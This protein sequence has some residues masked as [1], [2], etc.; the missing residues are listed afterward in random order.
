MLRDFTKSNKEYLFKNRIG[1]ICVTVFLIVGILV[2]ALFGM[3]GNFEVKSYTEFSIRA[4]EDSSKYAAIVE[5]T[6]DI[7]NS[8]KADYDNYLILGEGE[9]TEIV[10]RYTEKI[11]TENQIKLNDK[12]AK[13]LN[14]DI[15]EHTYVQPIVDDIDYVYTVATILVLILI[16]V[17]FAYFR[18]NGASA[19]SLALSCLIATLGFISI[20]SILRLSIGMSYFAMLVVLNLIVTYFAF[21]IFESIRNSSLLGN[22]DYAVALKSAIKDTKLRI[23]L[24]SVAI[25]IIGVLFVVAAP[26]TL[27]YVCL[28]IMFM[29]VVSLAT[30]WYVIPFF[31]SIFITNPNN[32]T[33]KVKVTKEDTN[34]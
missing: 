33:Y 15:S 19:V 9:N 12:L 23:S 11:S 2:L 27:K 1:I 7:V 21:N 29:S 32:K 17:L 8:Y 24:V 30:A 20:G 18:Y 3:N 5:E 13:E 10:I 16:A 25:M 28:N 34:K 26:A 4:G 31:W 22:K 14:L 6:K